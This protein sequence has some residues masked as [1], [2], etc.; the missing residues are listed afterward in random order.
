[1]KEQKKIEELYK[2]YNFQKIESNNDYSVFLQDFGYFKNLEAIYEDESKID[3][4]TINDEYLKS[5][6]STPKYYKFTDLKSLHLNL[7]KGFF[8]FDQYKKALQRSYMRFKEERRKTLLGNE[9]C[10]IPCSYQINYKDQKGNISLISSLLQDIK[11]SSGF[12]ILEAAA[13]FGKTCATFELMNSITELD[14]ADFVP[15][16]I[17]LSKNRSAPIFHYVLLD[18]IDRNFPSLKSDLVL[19]EIKEGNIPLIIDGFDELLSTDN[20]ENDNSERSKTM[21]QTLFELIGDDSKAKIILTSRKTSLITNGVLEKIIENDHQIKRYTILEPDIKNWLSPELRSIFKSKRFEIEKLANPI[22]LTML[23]NMDDGES[24]VA[25]DFDFKLLIDKYLNNLLLREKDRQE[26]LLTPEE[27]IELFTCFTK[28]FVE[29]NIS[30]DDPEMINLYLREILTQNYHEEN[31]V[32][33]LPLLSDI[34]KKYES[35]KTKPTEEQFIAKLSRH[36]L[37]DSSKTNN[38]QIGFINDFLFAVFIGKVLNK[39]PMSI[40]QEKHIDI[41]ATAYT[42]MPEEDKKQLFT[43]LEKNL[44]S[45]KNEF[46]IQI[47]NLLI[48]HLSKNYENLQLESMIFTDFDFSKEYTINFSFFQSCRFKRCTFSDKIQKSQFFNCQFYECSYKEGNKFINPELKNIFVDCNGN[49]PNTYETT[50]AIESD[51][52]LYEKR[53][54]EQYWAKGR[55]NAELRRYP[56]TLYRGFDVSEYKE[57]EYAVER[58]KRKCFLTF[59]GLCYELNTGKISEIKKIL[60][61]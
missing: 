9:Y 37:L 18:E 42:V 5:G 36:A 34:L 45:Q 11:T 16:F 14:D 27:Q 13:G 35:Y 60:G 41:L 30:S 10:Y 48:K 4:E 8:R 52:E 21:I 61:R 39:Y 57:V 53:V 49:L 6:Y 40:L 56:K 26:L 54:L 22:L 29:F 59:T 50:K 2:L 19:E 17:E 44:C 24:F 51:E 33:Y 47:D 12:F 3:R 46:I 1:M 15:L 28:Y 20:Q 43:V 23:K 58:L 38:N 32:K 55:P 31:D 7:F 25:T